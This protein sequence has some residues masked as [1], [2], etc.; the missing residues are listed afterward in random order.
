MRNSVILLTL[1]LT[2]GLIP[3]T[4]SQYVNEPGNL[5]LGL[6]AGL[7]FHDLSGADVQGDIGLLIGVWGNY[8]L[9]E[10]FGL[11]AELIYIQQGASRNI[12]FL[13]IDISANYNIDYV[14]IP[15]MVTFHPIDFIQ[16]HGGIQPSI[17]VNKNVETSTGLGQNTTLDD[18]EDVDGF[19]DS[20]FLA[21]VTVFLPYLD[22]KLTLTGTIRR[23]LI[24]IAK[25]DE[26]NFKN[27]GFAIT[28]GY[29]LGDI[30][31]YF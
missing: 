14:G 29:R 23:G 21:G 18:I 6:H 17:Q 13:G 16:I 7:N 5:D 8:R 26:V 30:N 27:R 15:L 19:F 4:F 28:V 1:Y 11:E 22:G 3:L 25:N 20:P 9:S 24:N 31:D 10:L 2:F 12:D